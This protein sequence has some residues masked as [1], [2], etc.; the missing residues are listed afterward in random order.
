M[1]VKNIN[2]NNNNDKSK[3]SG[4]K[5][6]QH[7]DHPDGLFMG[8]WKVFNGVMWSGKIFMSEGNKKNGITKSKT[9]KQWVGVTLVF[10]APL[11]ND[12][13]CNGTMNLANNKCYFDSW[14]WMA[15]PNA[16]NGG[17]IGKHISKNYD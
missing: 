13:L 7:V 4:C 8:V 15:N 16:N 10:S 14:N 12:V 5:L 17:Y 11:H 3:T 2:S 9:N 6:H 1:G